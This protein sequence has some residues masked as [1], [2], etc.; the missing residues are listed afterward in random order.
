MRQLVAEWHKHFTRQANWTT[1]VRKY[2]LKR[3]NLPPGA[4]VLEVG[5]GS[6]ALLTDPL[7]AAYDMHGVDLDLERLQYGKEMFK[8]T[9]MIG[10]NGYHLPFDAH[11]FDLVYCHYLLL[12]CKDPQAILNEM[13]R[14]CKIGGFVTSFGEPDYNS[15]IDYPEVYEKLGRLQNHSLEFQGV[16]L[17]IGRRMGDL[18]ISTGLSQV[19]IGVIGFERMKQSMED[20]ENE[21]ELIA[22][23]LGGLVPLDDI[24]EL[25]AE[26]K[27]LWTEGRSTLFIPTFYAFGVKN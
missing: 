4:R 25:R 27:K 3:A 11:S 6:G 19:N 10:S 13:Y 16:N 24:L 22:Y 18:F 14:V 17:S 26:A 15:R 8:G 9:K 5:S 21:W 12:W 23:D 1:R 20:F 7:F 2:L